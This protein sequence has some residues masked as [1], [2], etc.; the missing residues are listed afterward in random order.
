MRQHSSINQPVYAD[1]HLL[2]DFVSQSVTLD[3]D[4]LRLTK[5]EY[6]LLAHIVQHAGEV[7][8]RDTLLMEVWGYGPATRT[9]TVD[10][11][12]LRLRKKL[13]HYADRGIETVFG[14]GY[15][16][17]PRHDAHWSGIPVVGRHR[18][19]GH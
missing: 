4:G 17:Q 7:V 11:H 19:L 8:T 10:V 14:V 1:V 13:G 3:G 9:R 16:F 15:R 6:Q 18:R 12:V 5:K 2:L